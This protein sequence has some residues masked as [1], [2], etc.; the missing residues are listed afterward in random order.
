MFN[1]DQ[2]GV[3]YKNPTP[4]TIDFSGV[5]EA[6]VHTERNEKKRITTLSLLNAEGGLFPQMLVFRGVQD[7]PF[8]S[9]F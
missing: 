4:R 9:D 7:P 6:N 8:K 2:T 5:R 3:L 1:T